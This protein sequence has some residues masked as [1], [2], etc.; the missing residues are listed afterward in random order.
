MAE[1]RASLTQRLQ[2]AQR[3]LWCEEEE[4]AYIRRRRER[5]WRVRK[6]GIQLEKESTKEQPKIVFDVLY[7]AA[8]A[9]LFPLVLVATMFGSN[10][11]SLPRQVRWSDCLIGGAVVAVV[12][13]A[14]FV[15]LYCLQIPKMRKVEREQRRHASNLK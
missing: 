10:Q 14:L 6:E 15:V 11:D 3:V 4:Q 1:L 2:D 8:S 13:L 5:S 7:F 9:I 12:L